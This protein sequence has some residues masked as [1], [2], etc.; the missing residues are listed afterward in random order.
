MFENTEI[1]SFEDEVWYRKPNGCHQP[2]KEDDREFIR[3]MMDKIESFYPEAFNSLKTEYAK[4]SPNITYYQ[5]RIVRR[6]CRCNFGI[7][8]DIKDIDFKIYLKSSN[9]DY[10]WNPEHSVMLKDVNIKVLGTL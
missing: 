6:F 2:L 5:Y 8:D 9:Q 4:C 3:F 1:Y 10:L 7:I